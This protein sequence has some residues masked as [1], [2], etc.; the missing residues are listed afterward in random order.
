[1]TVIGSVRAGFGN[2]NLN[3]LFD[4]TRAVWIAGVN[5]H[6]SAC[7]CGSNFSLFGQSPF[8]ERGKGNFS[9]RCRRMAVAVS[10]PLAEWVSASLTR[11]HR[12]SGEPNVGR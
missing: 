4:W 6:L 3:Q 10:L 8:S 11:G 9:H 5:P 7:I 1:M 2:A 12:A